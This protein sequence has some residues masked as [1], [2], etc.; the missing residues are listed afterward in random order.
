MKFFDNIKNIFTRSKVEYIPF[1]TGIIGGGARVDNNALSISTVY[2]CVDIISDNIAILP[3][4]LKNKEL[5]HISEVFNHPLNSVFEN[6]TKNNISFSQLLRLLVQSVLLH[7]AGFAYI[8]R[9]NKGDVVNL[10]FLPTSTVTIHYDDKSDTLFYTSN[11]ITG[12]I[13]PIN[14]LHIIKNSFDGINGKSVIG[15]AQKSIYNTKLAEQQSTNYLE[16]GCNTQGVIKVNTQLNDKQ[17]TEILNQWKNA[18]SANGSG[19]AVF[20]GGMEYVPIQITP[21]Q[22]Q[23]VETKHYNTEDICRFFGIPI[24]FLQANT[25]SSSQLQQKLMM[26]LMPYIKLIEEE[27][28]RKLLKPLSESNLYLE[29]DVTNCIKYNDIEIANY[30]A[31]L[32]DKGI[33]CINEV[34]KC[35]G[36][37]AIEGGDKHIL[38]YTDVEQNTINKDNNTVEND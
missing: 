23:L 14:M 38:A 13:E 18:F 4:K 17:K 30:Y 11:L 15:A 32:L 37:N 3:I 36:Y 5:D 9:N 27:F 8:Q 21:S 1:S 34:R 19:I 16:S 20:Q 22:A 33:L 28:N 7:G 24:E 35:L 26:T 2:R 6:R 10:K 12:A 31:T 25:L 29:F